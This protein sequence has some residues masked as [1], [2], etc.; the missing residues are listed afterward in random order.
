[1]DR[2]KF[3]TVSCCRENVCYLLFIKSLTNF[4]NYHVNQILILSPI[5]NHSNL[6]TYTNSKIK[7][8]KCGVSTVNTDKTRMTKT[9]LLLFIIALTAMM[10]CKKDK[11]ESSSGVDNKVLINEI[12]KAGM[13]GYSSGISGKSLIKSGESSYPINVSVTSTTQGPEGGTIQVL[14]SI[15]GTMNIDDQTGSFLGGTLLL[16][17]TET[18]SDYAF[19]CNGQKFIMNGA[20]YLSLTGTFTVQ[21]DGASFGTASSM[22][23]GGGVQVTGPEFDQTINLDITII[24]NT[25]GTGGTVSGTIGGDQVNYTF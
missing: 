9:L 7:T 13:T 10:G 5:V 6:N 16:G 20:P 15:T 18:I 22:H 11:Q 4:T 2:G 3:L 19:L 17:L 14:G 1:M 25:N 8:K 23:F 24:L 21:P 12:F